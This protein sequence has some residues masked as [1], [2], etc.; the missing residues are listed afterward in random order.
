MIEGLE[1]C[2]GPCSFP[3]LPCVPT[4]FLICLTYLPTTFSYHLHPSSKKI[5]RGFSCS[6]IPHNRLELWLSSLMFPTIFFLCSLIISLKPLGDPHD[7]LSGWIYWR[8]SRTRTSSSEQQII[9]ME[10][11]WVKIGKNAINLSHW[12][13]TLMTV[14]AS[15]HLQRWKIIRFLWYS[16]G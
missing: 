15:E 12:W 10:I 5:D 3:K 7:L 14:N 6:C 13:R 2:A 8:R 4:V 9:F 11:R 1:P 16:A